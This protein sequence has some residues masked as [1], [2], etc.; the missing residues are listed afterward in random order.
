[1][2]EAIPDFVFKRMYYLSPRDVRKNRADPVHI[3]MSCKAFSDHGL[4]V[5]LV[6]PRVWRKGWHVKLSEIWPLY[7]IEPN[8]RIKELPTFVV[9]GTLLDRT[10]R[11]Q[12][13]C[14]AF[15]YFTW[16]AISDWF[17]SNSQ[18]E[19]LIYSKCYSTVVAP[20]LVRKFL[21]TK[22]FVAFEKPDFNKTKSLHR[23]V[24]RSVDAVVAT[25]PAVVEGL[26][27]SLIHI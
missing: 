1:M 15:L 17:R 24:C 11:I 21:R 14:F 6:A 3:M 2:T 13:I 22:W 5:C 25:T 26:Q 27:L 19:S 4:D 8:F 9:E 23:F 16:L 18:S 10:L 20:L 12:Q 7:N